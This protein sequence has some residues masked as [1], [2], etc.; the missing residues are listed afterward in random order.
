MARGKAF[1]AAFSTQQALEVPET[2]DPLKAT[3]HL[4]AEPGFSGCGEPSAPEK[5]EGVPP[6]GPAPDP[7]PTLAPASVPMPTAKV[8]H[9]APGS[10][11]LVVFELENFQGPQ[12][13]FSRECLN[14]GDRGFDGVRSLIVTSGPWS[15]L[16]IRL[17]RGN[18]R[19]EKGQYPP[20]DTWS[21]SYRSDRLMSFRPVRRALCWVGYQYPCY[22][23]DQYLLEPGD[24]RHWNEWGALQPQMQALRRLRDRQWHLEGCFPVLAAEPPK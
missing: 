7:G 9:L 16:S 3:G 10:Y 1:G 12:V 2:R 19:P 11:R 22:L 18:V 23:G 6:A 14:P 17:P 21:S 13:E 4:V 24:F 15:P 8:G 20:W 5:G